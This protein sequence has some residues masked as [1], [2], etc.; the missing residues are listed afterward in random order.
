M[1]QQSENNESPSISEKKSLFFCRNVIAKKYIYWIFFFLD[2]RLNAGEK[3]IVDATRFV[4]DKLI[5]SNHCNEY[6]MEF[7]CNTVTIAL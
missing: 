4:E 2:L 5:Q 6:F 7:S 1:E 3:K